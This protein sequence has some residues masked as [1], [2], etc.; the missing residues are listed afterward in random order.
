MQILD[1]I[2]PSRLDMIKEGPHFSFEDTPEYKEMVRRA[3]DSLQHIQDSIRAAA[4][5][6]T[7]AVSDTIQAT[8]PMAGSAGGNDTMS[9]LF[10]LLGSIAALSMCAYLIVNINK[11]RK[12]CSC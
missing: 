5:D 9:L 8:V 3:T 6:T 10:T 2:M 1:I 12:P 7:Q 4:T 11:N